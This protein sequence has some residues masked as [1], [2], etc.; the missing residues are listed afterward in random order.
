MT[1]GLVASTTELKYEEGDL[2]TLSFNEESVD[3]NEF[4]IVSGMLSDIED[5]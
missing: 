3:L 2:S 1:I 4:F 5:G